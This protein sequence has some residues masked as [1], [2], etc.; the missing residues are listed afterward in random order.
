M[1]AAAEQ[2][3]GDRGRGRGVSRLGD[4]EEQPVPSSQDQASA[5]GTASTVAGFGRGRERGS[6]GRAQ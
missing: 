2:L 5:L 6:A 4:F 1:I 3:G